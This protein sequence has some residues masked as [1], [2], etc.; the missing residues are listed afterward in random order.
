M[1]AFFLHYKACPCTEGM[2]G[3]KPRHS[4]MPAIPHS[5]AC[6]VPIYYRL[7]F[8]EKIKLL[9]TLGN[10]Y[11][12]VHIKQHKGVER[13]ILGSSTDVSESDARAVNIVIG[14]PQ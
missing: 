9:L 14:P 13:D 10:P 3:N 2:E 8:A 5:L 4:I 12:K 7:L 11:G 6:R 1:D